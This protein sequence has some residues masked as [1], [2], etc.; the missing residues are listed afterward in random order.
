[1]GQ[2]ESVSARAE[3]VDRAPWWVSRRDELLDLARDH[4]NAYVY[5]SAVIRSAVA[6]LR[7]LRSIDR[8][9]YSMKANFNPQVLRLLAELGVDFECVSPGEIEHLRATVRGLDSRRILFTPN[10][11][12]RE[13]YAWAMTHDVQVTLD[14]LYPLQA[15]PELFRGRRLFVRLDPGKGHGHHDHVK[16]AGEHSKFGIPL[17]EAD[18]LVSLIDR[19]AAEVIGIHAHIGSGIPISENWGRVA[20]QLVAVADRFPSAQVIDVGGGLGV[21]ARADEPAFDLA[22]LDAAL[23][24]VKARHPGYRFWLEPGRYFVSEAGILLTH[25]TQTKGKGTRKYVG[26]AA[27]MNALIRPALYNAWHDIANLSR[28]G[29]AATETVTVVGPICESGDRLGTDRL[30]PPCREND[31]IVIANVG[32]YGRSMASE[33]NLRPIPPE[34]VL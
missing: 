21:P 12:P 17:F 3:Q 10:F 13:D 6:R 23:A 14:N 27:G 4:L 19:C 30:L 18:E 31:V 26:V 20:E 8:L 11:A 15:W 24:A 5:D 1:M 7:G 9:L 34:I 22:G 28:W 33:Y 16:T 2:Q 32:A 25:V 29:E